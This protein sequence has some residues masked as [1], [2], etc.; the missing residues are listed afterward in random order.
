MVYVFQSQKPQ[1]QEERPVS[2]GPAVSESESSGNPPGSDSVNMS[3]RSED[4]MSSEGQLLTQGELAQKRAE[5]LDRFDRLYK[6]EK[7]LN[8]PVNRENPLVVE[9]PR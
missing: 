7:K 3:N 8:L 2:I 1:S 6:R 5:I 9:L 4:Q